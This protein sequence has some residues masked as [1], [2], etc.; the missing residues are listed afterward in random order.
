LCESSGF[1]GNRGIAATRARGEPCESSVFV[2]NRETAASR[3][4]GEP[5]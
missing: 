1:V 5:C 2:E 4:R 3:A